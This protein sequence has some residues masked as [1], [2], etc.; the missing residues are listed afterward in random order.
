MRC[1]P[2]PP[3][4]GTSMGSVMPNTVVGVG[5]N[6][7]ID[8]MADTLLPDI[9]DLLSAISFSPKVRMT[10]F[11]VTDPTLVALRLA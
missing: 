5:V 7:I 1:P 6:H 3:D 10:T 4:P 9:C 11:F 2:G 8:A